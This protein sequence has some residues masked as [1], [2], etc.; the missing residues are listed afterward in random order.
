M[1]QKKSLSLSRLLLSLISQKKEKKKSDRQFYLDFGVLDRKIRLLFF[2]GSRSFRLKAFWENP[3]GAINLAIWHGVSN[4]NRDLTHPPNPFNPVQESTNPTL[5]MVSRSPPPEPKNDRSVGVFS[6]QNSKKPDRIE[7]WS[8]SQR[9]FLD[10]ARS[11]L[12]PWNLHRIWQD[13]AESVE[14]LSNSTKI[15]QKYHGDF[16]INSSDFG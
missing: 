16:A 12:D 13:L 5:V 3:R 15:Q 1:S 8:I 11:Q 7:I 14:I 6:S 9:S 2:V 10:P 4:K